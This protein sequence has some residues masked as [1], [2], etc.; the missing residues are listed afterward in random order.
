MTQ[1]NTSGRAAELLTRLAD[2]QSEL[3]LLRKQRGKHKYGSEGGYAICEEGNEYLVAGKIYFVRDVAYS[4][5]WVVVKGRACEYIKH[6]FRPAA[7]EEIEQAKPLKFGMWTRCKKDGAIG[8]VI[9]P[10]PDCDGDI[11]V[12]EFDADGHGVTYDYQRDEFTVLRRKPNQGFN[13]HN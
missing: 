5:D 7:P 6:R 10:L 11:Q 12:I 1:P 8:R 4:D 2:T 9:D 13:T 3:E